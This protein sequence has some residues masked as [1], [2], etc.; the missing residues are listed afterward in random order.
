VMCQ[1][2]TRM[3]V[4]S[5]F[6]MDE[7][8][9]LHRRRALGLLARMRQYNKPWA[10]YVFSS[11]NVLRSYTMEQL[12]GLGVS[13]VWMGIEGKNSQYGKL[14]GIDTFALVRKLQSHGTRVL[15]STIIGLEEH[16]PDNI[17]R[18]I[19]HAVC[20]DTDFH[21]FMLYTPIPGTPLHAEM[22]AEGRM[23]A[24]GEFDRADI[25]GQDRLNY[26]HPH[27]S[28]EQASA[29]LVQAFD[30]DFAVNGPSTIRIVRT[31]LR[32]WKRY[33]NHPDPR[34]RARFAYEARELST[35]MT[36]LVAG[37][38]R[39]YRDQPAMHRKLSQLLADLHREFGLK[40]RISSAVGGPWVHRQIR[41]EQKR[42]ADGWTY[43]PPTF[44]ERNASVTD[45][46]AAALCSV[47]RMER[48]AQ[49][50][51]PPG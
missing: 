21:Q 15:G 42:L 44:Y 45:H 27:L 34:I 22:T 23:K 10:L 43:E 13:W 29:A 24:D 49:L 46:P 32:G 9:L 51:D 33:R 37:A 30:R 47:S 26:H 7:N 31:T 17:D 18:A 3:Q 4:N 1:M 8:F 12:V 16:T 41:K 19:D 28:D 5:F 48:Q 20:H 11:A 40:S 50:A 35:A 39:F 36:A 25:H 14:D 2:E 6:M 38:R